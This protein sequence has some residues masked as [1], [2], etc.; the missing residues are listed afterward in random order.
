MSPSTVS[1][2]TASPTLTFNRLLRV[3]WFYV[4]RL[5][6]IG[7]VVNYETGYY[8]MGVLA[9]VLRRAQLHKWIII[10][11]Q[12]LM[13]LCLW[14]G[15]LYLVRWLVHGMLRKNFGDFRVRLFRDDHSKLSLSLRDTLRIAWLLFW[16]A[17]ILGVIA[18]GIHGALFLE[19]ERPI[20]RAPRP[21][22]LPPE[23]SWLLLFQF[24]QP[25][26]FGYP[27]AVSAML[28]KRFVGFHFGLV[29]TNPESCVSTNQAQSETA[30]GKD[31]ISET[32]STS[33]GIRIC[34]NCRMRVLPAGGKCPSCSRP[35][36]LA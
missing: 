5:F 7:V 4:W 3:A 12:L 10:L 15:I 19:E 20:L 33:M 9:G 25:W 14:I 26:F 8:G 32:A 6:L 35:M 13:N 1:P 24:W 34:E 2:T 28:R 23:Q 16:R 36:T 18:G 17:L 22:A 31:S 30:S 27:W 11:I 29:E 21:W